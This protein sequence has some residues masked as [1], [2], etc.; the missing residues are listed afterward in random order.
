MQTLP[1]I[2]QHVASFSADYVTVTGGEPLAQPTCHA[3]LTALCDAG[4]HV[5]LE[6]SGAIDIKEVDPRVMIVMD[7]KTPDSQEADKNIW[8]NLKY[9][10]PTDQIKFV[11]CSEADFHWTKQQIEHYKLTDIC[12]ILLSPSWSQVKLSQLADWILARNSKKW[13]T[14]LF[15]FGGIYL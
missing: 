15:Y 10:K 13:L 14:S 5:S 3:L 4:Y 6:T 1:E 2:L 7:L 12:Q 9:L 11:V 8:D